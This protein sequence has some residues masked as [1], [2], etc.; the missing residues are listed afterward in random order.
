MYAETKPKDVAQYKRVLRGRQTKIDE[1]IRWY[2]EEIF[3]VV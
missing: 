3:S 2:I 1:I